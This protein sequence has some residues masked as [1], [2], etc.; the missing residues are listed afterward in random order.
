MYRLKAKWEGKRVGRNSTSTPSVHHVENYVTVVA[1]PATAQVA[2][3]FYFTT[4]ALVMYYFR[5]GKAGQ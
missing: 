1:L 2:I 4:I 5:Y 3:D